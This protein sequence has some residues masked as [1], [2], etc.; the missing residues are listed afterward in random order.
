VALQSVFGLRPPRSQLSRKFSFYEV[1]EPNAQPPTLQGQHLV[2]SGSLLCPALR[3]VRHLPLSSTSLCP[4]P[5]FVRH[6]ALSGTSLCP[7][8]RLKLD[9]Y[10]WP[11]QQLGCRRPSLRFIVTCKL[12]RP[13]DCAFLKV[14]IPYIYVMNNMQAY[15]FHVVSSF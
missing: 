11:C 6:L 3:F 9:R 13:A 4:A 7:T 8:P 10:G 14:E 15:T 1:C 2:L 5:P 12:L